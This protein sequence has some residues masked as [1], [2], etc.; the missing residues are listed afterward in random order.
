MDIK[1]DC[2]K[3]IARAK[4]GKVYVWCKHCKKEVPIKLEVEPYEPRKN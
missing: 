2:G 1:C 3:L 4:D